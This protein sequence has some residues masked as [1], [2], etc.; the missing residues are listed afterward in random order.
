MVDAILDFRCW[1]PPALVKGLIVNGA[2]GIH[3]EDEMRVLISTCINKNMF[4]NKIK[5]H[6]EDHDYIDTINGITPEYTHMST[7]GLPKWLANPTVISSSFEVHLPCEEDVPVFEC[8][9]IEGLFPFQQEV[10]E[11]LGSKHPEGSRDLCVSAPTGSGK[12]L[13]YV[14]PIVEGLKGRIVGRVRAVVVVPSKDLVPQVEETFKSVCV[15]FGCDLRSG[16]DY[17]VTTPGKLIVQLPETDLASLKYLV[18]DEADRL[19]DQSFQEWLPQLLNSLKRSDDDNTYGWGCEVQK[20]LFSATLTTNPAKIAPLNLH[21]PLYLTLASESHANLVTPA[22]LKELMVVF[23]G[24]EEMKPAVLVEVLEK[25]LPGVAGLKGSERV[26]CFT[27]SVTSTHRL[28]KLL[29]ALC[30]ALRVSAF[31][32]HLSPVARQDLLRA[33]SSG[34]IQVLV[35]SDAMARGLDIQG[36]EGVINYDLPGFAG[37]YVHRVGRTARAGAG[38]WAISITPGSQ[39]RHFKK[40]L[41]TTLGKRVVDHAS[42]GDL[43]WNDVGKIELDGDE[44]EA[45]WRSKLQLALDSLRAPINIE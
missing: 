38:G 7:S 25:I 44:I 45:K 26:L 28:T 13:A 43:G 19:L 20:L 9:G 17:L 12:T 22:T 27:K 42:E 24:A 33:F 5:M 34:L 35:G 39:T 18:V 29:G 16:T 3:D 11:R 36:V 2:C 41:R 30:P 8:L 23:E 15:A 10:R 40:M 4:I 1:I 14:L 31:H 21:R 32:G 6:K 37:T